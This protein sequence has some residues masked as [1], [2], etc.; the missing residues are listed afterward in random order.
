MDEELKAEKSRLVKCSCQLL[1]CVYIKNNKNI[2]ETQEKII[3]LFFV[4]LKQKC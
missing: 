4:L 1:M 3:L 2:K